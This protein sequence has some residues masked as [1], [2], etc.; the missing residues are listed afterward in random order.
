L[1][2][3]NRSN[4]KAQE[5][6]KLFADL[7]ASTDLRWVF[8]GDNGSSEKDLEA[9]EMIISEYP[10]ALRAVFMHAVSGNEQPATL[11]EVIPMQLGSTKALWWH[12]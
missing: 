9:A 5:L 10:R 6:V 7:A 1:V 8:V 3:A 11:P 4:A 2:I 12:P